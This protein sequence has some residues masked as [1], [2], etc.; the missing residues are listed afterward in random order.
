MKGQ[1]SLTQILVLVAMVYLFFVVR[2]L[3]GWR[4][5]KRGAA[6][7]VQLR[8]RISVVIP[9]RNEQQ[10]LP[11][12]FA[13]LELLDYSKLDYEVILIDDHS[14]DVGAELAKEWVAKTTRIARL[15]TNNGQG[16]KAAQALGVKL[17][18]FEIIACTDADCEVP[19]MWLS[20]INN[21]FEDTNVKLAFGPVQFSGTCHGLQSLEF[22]SLIA[23]TVAMLKLGWPVMGNAANMAFTKEVYL[24]SEGALS[25]M[26]SASGDDVFLLHHVTKLGSKIETLHSVV[27]TKPQPDLWSFLNQ[28]LRWAA[29]AKYYR[30]PAA[31]FVGALVLGVNI[32]LLTGF[33]ALLFGATLPNSF[34][35]LLVVKCVMDFILLQRSAK[36]FNQRLKP[37]LF[38]VQEILNV[39]YV[40]VVAALSQFMH[41]TWKGRRY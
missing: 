4:M 6:K 14:T 12:L 22:L 9:F 10:N 40:P 37:H 31:L 18:N 34:W 33:L 23:S 17:A 7:Q 36:N 11:N 26:P 24:D 30:Q 19:A 27:T 5:Y 8:K 41:F 20:D 29:K 21:C 2:L 16:K 15:I 3:R 25:K 32:I 39:V 35:F 28:R 1:D 13:S 38:L